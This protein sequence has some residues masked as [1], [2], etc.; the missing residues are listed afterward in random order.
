MVMNGNETELQPYYLTV[1][2]VA[3][4]GRSVQAS[5][6]GVYIDTTP[7]VIQMIYH[8][9]LSWS[10][11]EPSS[12][13]G[14][15]TSMAVYYEAVDKESEVINRQRYSAFVRLLKALVLLYHLL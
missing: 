11:S 13:Q 7:P 3:G 8:V 10:S 15:N 14:G 4:S 12:F 2:A 5:S 6:A 1:K 9:D